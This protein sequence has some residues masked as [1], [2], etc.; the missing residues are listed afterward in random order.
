[1]SWEHDYQMNLEEHKVLEKNL[2]H[3]AAQFRIRGIYLPTTSYPGRHLICLQW[4]S[5]PGR[6][7]VILGLCLP[8]M[9]SW[10]ERKEQARALAGCRRE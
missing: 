9:T 1:M 4:G 8:W 5:S 7:R 10:E 3:L 6:R 2:E